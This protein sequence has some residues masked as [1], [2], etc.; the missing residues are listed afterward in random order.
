MELAWRTFLQ[1]E[2]RDY[3]AEGIESFR[4]F[5]SDQWLKKMFLKG[6]YTMILA[7]DEEKIIGLITL[8][9][10]CHISLLFVDGDYHRQGVGSSLVG[11]LETWLSKEGDMHYMTVNAAPYALGFYHKIGFWD[12]ADQQEKEGILYTPMKMNF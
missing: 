12:L 1:F 10:R 3:T 5:I 6:E 7:L 9:S 4:D 2:A 8:R 11:A